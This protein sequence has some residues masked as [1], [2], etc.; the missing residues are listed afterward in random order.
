ML[1]FGA[2]PRCKQDISPERKKLSPIICNHCGYSTSG[3]AEQIKVMAEKQT[4]IIYSTLC[5]FALVSFFQ[6]SNWDNH[7]L[8]IIPLKIKDTF[9][10]SSPSDNERTAEICMDLKKWDCV[11][12]NYR[13]V[14]QVDATKLPRLGQFQMKRSKYNEAAQTFYTLLPEG[15]KRPGVQLQL[16]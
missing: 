5:A 1:E 10:M 14:G 3:R 6:L 11:E 13:K 12:S 16:R 4:I 9:G 7:A 15:R 2:C 8:E